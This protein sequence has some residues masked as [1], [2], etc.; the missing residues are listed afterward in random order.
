MN[1][2]SRQQRKAPI[3]QPESARP[4][5]LWSVLATA[6][7]LRL[8]YFFELRRTPFYDNLLLDL[9]AY[10]G[11]GRRIAQGD[12]IGARVFY[13]DP[14][15]PYFLGSIYSILGHRLA[16]V[17]LVQIFLG[18]LSC[19][20]VYWIAK[21]LFGA[22]AGLLAGT[23]AAIY[24]PFIFYDV[25]IEKSF[26]ATLLVLAA[27]ALLIRSLARPS[28]VAWFL[29]G[30]ALGLL[31]LVRGNYLLLVPIVL[32]AVVLSD[33]E[34]RFVR[35]LRTAGF[36]LL[37]VTVVLF[38]T[39]LRNYVV[40]RD[41]VLTTAQA[42]Q[43]FFIGNNPDNLTGMYRAPEFVRADPKFEEADFAKEAERL[44]ERP[45]KPSEISSFWFGRALAIV[46][47]DPAGFLKLLG[48]KT[49]LFW[50]SYEIPDNLDMYFFKRY[51]LLM[52]LWLP[53]FGLIAS[54]AA[55]GM[56]LS[57]REWRRL[58]PLYIFV[59]GYFVSVVFF[60]IFARY[61]LPV[62][63]FLM[64]FASRGLLGARGLLM[65]REF[66]KVTLLFLC[67]VAVA[68]AAHTPLLNAYNPSAID[69]LGAILLRM[70][71]LTGAEE[72]FRQVL[73]R[74][75]DFADAHNN[76]GVSLLR[77]GDIAGALTEFR[78]AIRLK[79]RLAN[80]Y[81][82]LGLGLLRAGD[83]EQARQIFGKALELDPSS[84]DAHSGLGLLQREMGE[85]ESALYSFRKAAD[86]APETPEIQNNLG[87]AL[88]GRGE[89]EEALQH[90]STASRLKDDF[91]EAHY[92][93]AICL[94]RLNRKKEA[95]DSYRQAIAKRPD[96]AEAYNNLG[97]LLAE[98]GDKSGAVG[99]YQNFLRHWKGDQR[100]REAVEGEI[101]K[102]NK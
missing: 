31:A 74:R 65:R 92:N 61:R 79:P 26:L 62:V 80:S 33:N 34:S 76:L 18:T 77:M 40:G 47:E 88:L 84:A 98:T 87:I 56:V 10:D 100:I 22:P 14:L 68:A 54:L 81:V 66:G 93:R 36:L 70:R 8:F 7:F 67:V 71:D 57:A 89:L 28:L 60:Y 49:A 78:E 83:R 99:A 3:S 59:F 45:L 13:Q 94:E 24:Q 90:L 51:S 63:P 53:A 12:W 1:T 23:M 15:Y 30:L 48:Y 101:R 72:L 29:A 52:R 42:G 44:A 75:P 64:V 55:A 38:L 46:R 73:A 21:R 4:Y 27:C 69:N 19:Y 95:V 32:F 82:N 91:A 35:R 11:W 9:A 96:Y 20:L 85:D 102:L 6:L 58:W 2:A 5:W 17:Y 43:N 37:G 25:Q 50:N 16:V 41:F 97:N 86:L 39:C